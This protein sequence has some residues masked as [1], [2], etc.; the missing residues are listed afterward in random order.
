MREALAAGRPLQ[1]VIVGRGLHG[2]RLEEILRLAKR[3]GV[4]VRFEDRLQLDRA[5]GTREHQGVVA[6]V[7]AS[8]AVSLHDLIVRESASEFAPGFARASRRCRRPSKSRRG[9][10]YGGAAA[11]AGGVIIPERRAG[12]LDRI[13]RRALQQGLS[14]TCP[15]RV[16]TNLA[17]AMQEL[18]EAGYWLVGLDER[19]TGATPTWTLLAV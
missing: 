13:W 11:G 18:K 5:A 17:R 1:T 10:P 4:P 6:L 8:T 7:A 2:G 15:S 9:Y 12:R 16:V 14:H 3:H 19:P